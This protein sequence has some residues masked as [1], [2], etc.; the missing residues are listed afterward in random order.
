MKQ[1]LP[2]PLLLM[3]VLLEWKGSANWTEPFTSG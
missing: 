1:S 2:V 3:K